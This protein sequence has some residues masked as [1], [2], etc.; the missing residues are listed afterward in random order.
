M[1]IAEYQLDYFDF[2]RTELD[3]IPKERDTPEDRGTWKHY[4]GDSFANSPILCKRIR[5]NPNWYIK[6]LRDIAENNCK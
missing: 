5:A 1:S 2:T 6:D 3:Y 4:L